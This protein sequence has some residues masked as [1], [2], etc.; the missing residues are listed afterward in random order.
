MCYRILA[1]KKI[2]AVRGMNGARTQE[3]FVL[4]FL[5][6]EF[7]LSQPKIKINIYDNIV[8]KISKTVTICNCFVTLL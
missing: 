3:D 8:T 6:S 4:E 5:P 7:I 1:H 2:R